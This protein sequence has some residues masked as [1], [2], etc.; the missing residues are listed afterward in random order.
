MQLELNLSGTAT[1]TAVKAQRDLTLWRI[2]A[3]NKE[4]QEAE[5]KLVR[6]NQKLEQQEYYLQQHN[7]V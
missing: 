7:A 6:L 2:T 3:A 4:L 5:A 1:V